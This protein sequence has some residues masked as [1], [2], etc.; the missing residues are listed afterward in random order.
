MDRNALEVVWA[1]RVLS[2]LRI[3][4]AL[5]FMQHGTQK[6]FGFPPSDHAGPELFSL[7][8]AQGL[9]EV[10]GG[11][12]VLIGQ[13]TRPVAFLLS[14]DMAAAYVM[15]HAPK[16]VFPAL[17][18][19]DAAALYC[20]IFL[21]LAVAGSGSWRLDVRALDFFLAKRAPS[22]SWGSALVLRSN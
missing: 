11:V 6:L 3:I 16:S 14:G 13:F 5:L 22:K 20:F 15:A 4:T 1:P 8:G 7:L 17:N 9:L 21:Y 18:G 19:G 2:V 10:L 12:L